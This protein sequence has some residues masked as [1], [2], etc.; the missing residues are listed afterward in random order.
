MTFIRRSANPY[1]RIRAPGDQLPVACNCVQIVQ[2]GVP[3]LPSQNAPDRSLTPGNRRKGAVCK[4][5]GYYAKGSRGPDMPDML[6]GCARLP[7]P[8]VIKS[9]RRRYAAPGPASAPALP[10]GA[11]R[12]APGQYAQQGAQV[13]PDHRPPRQ[14]ATV[15]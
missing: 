9:R 10:W 3:R 4:T 7:N 8:A 2:F 6:A 5:V 1:R 12:R 11:R 15:A 14:A 13:S